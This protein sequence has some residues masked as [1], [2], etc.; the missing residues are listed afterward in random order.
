MTWSP[1]FEDRGDGVRRR[2]ARRKCERGLAG[3]DGGHVAFERGSRRI[4]RP[5]VFVAL[6]P[7]QPS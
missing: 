3:L 7:A 6:V 1:D 5:G 2:H 4:L